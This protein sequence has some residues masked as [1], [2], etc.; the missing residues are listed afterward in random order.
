MNPG[1]CF[2]SFFFFENLDLNKFVSMDKYEKIKKIG[3][4]SYGK[5][6]TDLFLWKK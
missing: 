4:G 3:E 6:K 2:T 1:K 5:K